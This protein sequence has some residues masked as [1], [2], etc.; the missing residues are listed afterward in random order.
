MYAYIRGFVVLGVCYFG[1]LG[2]CVCVFLWWVWVFFFGFMGFWVGGFFWVLCFIVK[3]VCLVEEKKR[4]KL[5][6]FFGEHS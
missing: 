4:G 2:F 1:A 6:L 5:D 3:V